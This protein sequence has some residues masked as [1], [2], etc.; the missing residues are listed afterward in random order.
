M[1]LPTVTDARIRA[2]RGGREWQV[3]VPRLAVLR[4][5]VMESVGSPAVESLELEVASWRPP[6]AGW[7]GRPGISG[8]SVVELSAKDEG[9]RVVLSCVTP[10]DPG[11]L[12][13]AAL[14][15]LQSVPSGDAR[16]QLTFL[17]GA[18]AASSVLAAE[19]RDVVLVD[20]KRDRHV[21]RA[22]DLIAATDGED[23]VAAD[24]SS[25]RLAGH[26]T[27]RSCLSTSIPRFTGRWAV[28]ASMAPP[29]QQVDSRVMHWW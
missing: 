11:V 21:R 28:A 16:P 17:P 12:L 4:A 19:V 2:R 10:T 3:R 8:L 15:C 26:S 23:V 29:S 1:S 18:S 22:D 24:S 13:A 27:A 7:F 25:M 9:A 5:L 20:E 6:V 14:R